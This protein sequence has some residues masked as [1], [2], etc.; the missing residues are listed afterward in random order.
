MVHQ[1][2]IFI[3][4]HQTP[5]IKVNR[6]YHSKF[7]IGHHVLAVDK[8][9]RVLKN[10]NPRFHQIR[11][12]S[13]GNNLNQLLVRNERSHDADIHSPHSSILDILRQVI[14]NNQIRRSNVDIVRSLTDNILIDCFANLALI[15]GLRPAAIGN[16]KPFAF[17]SFIF[18]MVLIKVCDFPAVDVPVH[19]KEPRQSLDCPTFQAYTAIFPVSKTNNMIDILVSQIDTASIANLTINHQNLTVVTVI[20]G[21][22]HPRNHLVKLISLDAH[23]AQL[24]G[25]IARQSSHAAN[26]IIEQLDFNALRGFFDQDIQNTVPHQSFIDDIKLQKNEFLSS[27]QISQHGLKHRLTDGKIARS[28]TVID[29]CIIVHTQQ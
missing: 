26:I 29:I 13:T 9:W 25:I 5:V 12:G 10:L 16:V 7:I 3:M 20:I 17:N 18:Q 2:C 27:P 4:V 6:P 1:D 15:N 28:C 19:E 8:P 11:I 23:L 14:V 21:Y 22:R 24:T